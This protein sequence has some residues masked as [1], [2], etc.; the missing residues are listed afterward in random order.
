MSNCKT[1]SRI[2]TIAAFALTTLLFT[3]STWSWG[4]I[5]HQVTA[6]MAEARLTPAALAVVH[7]LL[8]T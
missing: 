2:R 6:R 7:D 1:N 8:G 4:C 5:A 3:P